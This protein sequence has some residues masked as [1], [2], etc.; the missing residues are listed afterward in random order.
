[1]STKYFGER[2]RDQTW[3]RIAREIAR[4]IKIARTS[5]RGQS[6]SGQSTQAG[7][8]TRARN[9]AMVGAIQQQ[10][11]GCAKTKNKKYGM[12]QEKDE[13]MPYRFPF[14]LLRWLKT[15]LVYN[16]LFLWFIFYIENYKFYYNLAHGPVNRSGGR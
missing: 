2:E 14:K 9:A 10:Y 16:N 7:G 1:M 11:F 12:Q 8:E 4:A 15:L 5:A 6:T 13:E 3:K